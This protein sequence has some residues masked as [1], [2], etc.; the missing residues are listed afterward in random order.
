MPVTILVAVALCTVCLA[1]CDDPL[2]PEVVVVSRPLAPDPAVVSMTGSGAVTPP[3]TQLAIAWGRAH[4][5]PRVVVEPSV[6]STGG[7]RAAADGAADI[8]MIARPLSQ[9]ELAL[10]LVLVPVARDAVVIAA[11]PGVAIDGIA[12][13]ELARLLRGE[14]QRFTDG[15]PAVVMLRDRDDSAHGA[16]EVMFPSL[17]EPR[18]KAYETGRFRV[19]RHDDAMGEALAT[20]PGSVGVFSLGAVMSGRLRLKV[21]AIDGRIASL[22]SVEDGTWKATRDLA[23]VVRPDRLAR[24]R[25]FLAFVLGSEGFSVLRENGYLPIRS[26]VP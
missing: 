22:S 14:E 6:G 23:F 20:T 8:G 16:L 13:V 26:T 4:H 17:R 18:E 9:K 19:L 21:L 15:S 7:I 11:H 3:A 10:G 12:S 25:P 24:V 5:E 1:G 2:P